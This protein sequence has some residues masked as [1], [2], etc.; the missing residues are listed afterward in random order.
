MATPSPHPQRELPSSLP[1]QSKSADL[2]PEL[3][4]LANRIALLTFFAAFVTVLG[5]VL[6]PR[7]VQGGTM[8]LRLAAALP[9]LA[10]AGTVLYVWRLRSE[11]RRAREAGGR[12][13]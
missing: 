2:P 4:P 12:S 11:L 13:R 6:L 3:V 9:L 5:L 1:R 7:I 8:L 10:A